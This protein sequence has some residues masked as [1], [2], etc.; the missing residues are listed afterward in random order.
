M[1]KKLKIKHRKK[2]NKYIVDY[3]KVMDKEAI[4][5]ELLTMLNHDKNMMVFVDTSMNKIQESLAQGHYF[6]LCQEG[7]LHIVSNYL[8]ESGLEYKLRIRKRTENRVIMGFSTGKKEL[9][10]D[11]L[12]AINVPRGTLTREL[13]DYT[14]C[15]HDFIIGI[16]PTEPTAAI[17]RSFSN[18]EFDR[19]DETQGFEQ[20]LVDS[21]WMGYFYT[22]Y[23]FDL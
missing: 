15:T 6:D 22:D 4:R 5:Y 2:E 11:V 13:F 21:H 3:G 19:L 10:E 20:I 23:K 9:V 18:N 17:M 14:M 1:D 12:I 8:E 16:S 7:S